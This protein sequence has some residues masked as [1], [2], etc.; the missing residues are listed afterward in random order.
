M[1]IIIYVF[2]RVFTVVNGRVKEVYSFINDDIQVVGGI[3][4]LLQPRKLYLSLNGQRTN[5]LAFNFGTDRAV[6]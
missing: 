2:L 4:D 6:N 3:L 1:R 5:H